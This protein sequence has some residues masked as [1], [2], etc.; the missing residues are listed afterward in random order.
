MGKF[1]TFAAEAKLTQEQAQSLADIYFEGQE[2]LVNQLATANQKAWDTTIDTWKAEIDTDPVIG[3]DKS[4]AAMEVIGKVLDEYGTAD[5]RRAFEVTGAGWNPH[6]ARFMHKMAL[7][8]T[9]GSPVIAPGPAKTGP[10]TL[11]DALYDG[12]YQDQ[13]A[14]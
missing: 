2:S 11:G 5:A 8:L 6:I 4:K 3:G 13:P 1:S 9:E 12:K 7:A 14:N 10:K